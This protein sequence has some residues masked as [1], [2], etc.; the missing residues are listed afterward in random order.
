M[1][2]TALSFRLIPIAC[3]PSYPLNSENANPPGTFTVYRSWPAT[4]RPTKTPA[5]SITA[6]IRF[7]IRSPPFRLP[8]HFQLFTRAK[9]EGH[10]AAFRAASTSIN[11]W[12]AVVDDAGF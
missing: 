10:Y 2:A 3:Q 1:T 12:A 9:H 11:A 8:Q 7:F 6:N 5:I 4:T